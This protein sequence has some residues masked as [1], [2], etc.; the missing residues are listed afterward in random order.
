MAS[1]GTGNV[2]QTS[3]D[4]YAHGFSGDMNRYMQVVVGGSVKF[5][6]KLT[7]WESSPYYGQMT[8]SGLT[9]GT[10]YTIKVYIGTSTIYSNNTLMYTGS[11][12]TESPPE[13]GAFYATD[14][15]LELDSY[16]YDT[17]YAYITAYVEFYNPNDVRAYGRGSIY[18][19]D[20]SDTGSTYTSSNQWVSAYNTFTVSKQYY[21]HIG[22]VFPKSFTIRGNGSCYQTPG[23]TSGTMASSG[24]ITFSDS[25]SLT[26]PGKFYW[27][28]S[29]SSLSKG[30]TISTYITATKWKALQTNINGVRAYK[31][32]SAYSFTT[33]SKGNTITAA[34]YNE[35][36]NAIN[37]I[38]SGTVSTVSKGATITAAAFNALQNGINGIS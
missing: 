37:G 21:W 27:I 38:K 22:G 10:T 19:Y 4:F 20:S 1:Y 16:D 33:V 9:A 14:A 6:G 2:T 25:V 34:L 8:V 23:S 12:T 26:R 3:F 18:I 13:N 35:I 15:W 17:G 31:G 11:C 30:S 5:S 7:T 36:A 29:S 32:K 24:Y 28:S